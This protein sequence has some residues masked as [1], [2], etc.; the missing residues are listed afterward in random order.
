[1]TVSKQIIATVLLG[2][3]AFSLRFPGAGSF[4]TVDEFNWM[5][6][7]QTFWHE[8]FYDRD[9]GGTF[10]TS[11]PGATATWLAG[12]GI[13]WQENQLGQEFSANNVAHFRRYATA[14]IVLTIAVL[15][16]VVTALAIS[17][18]GLVPGIITGLIL[19][20]EPYL[21]GMGQVVH[22][23]MLQA[24]FMLTALLGVLRMRV[25]KHRKWIWLVGVMFGLALATKMV[26]ALWLLP[27]IGWPLVTALA[28]RRG[29]NAII[30]EVKRVFTIIVLGVVAL[31]ILWPALLAQPDFQL[32]YISRDTGSV[33]TQEHVALS[34]GSDPIAPWTFYA[35]TFLARSSLLVLAGTLAAVLV[36]AYRRQKSWQWHDIGTVLLYLLGYL[37][38]IS[39]AAKKADRYALPALAALPL[40]V[41]WVVALLLPI[42][43]VR[44]KQL[45]TAKQTTVVAIG[46]I[47]VIGLASAWLWLPH[48]IAYN[49]PLFPDLR[50]RSQQGWGEGLEDAAA[51]LNQLPDAEQIRVASW[52]QSAFRAHFN[53]LTTSLSARD[54]YRVTYLVT[55]RNMGGRAGDTLASDVLD[56][57]KNQT[58]VHVVSIR[59]LEY[60]W[61]YKLNNVGEYIKTAGE[62]TTGV[63][64]GQTITVEDDGWSFMEIG[65]ATY[66]DRANTED[67]LV[68]IRQSIADTRDIRTIRIPVAD[69]IDNKWHEIEFEEIQDSGNK[70]YYVAI[71]SPTAT[72]GNAITTRY[73]DSDIQSGQLFIRRH[74]RRLGEDQAQYL[75][76]GDLAVRVPYWQFITH[77]T[78]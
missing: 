30:V 7:S 41:G 6:R 9:I 2:L 50:S 3:L 8:L 14:P 57:F 39:F 22:L 70:T 54:D 58:P 77:D 11:H 1:M 63:E 10:V 59:G 47:L 46:A 51:W 33:I 71:T 65:F 72:A 64:H 15:I 66:G 13:F 5:G 4:T 37:I 40:L 62:L 24:L 55:Y 34:A 78:Q 43:T 16:A 74:A 48:A 35:R 52:Y 27:F 32:G 17:V 53:G 45:R 42:A 61:I 60:A 69:I 26:L 49:N 31:A 36:L 28:L 23:D 18:F 19:A 75:R 67:V 25:D 21:I 20:T 68:H 38:A 73:T 76:A 44:I 29:R 12:A 56:E